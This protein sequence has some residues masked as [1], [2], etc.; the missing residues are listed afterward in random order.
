[1][2]F[3]TLDFEVLII[4]FCV[5]K[6]KCRLRNCNKNGKKLKKKRFFMSILHF[7][8]FGKPFRLTKARWNMLS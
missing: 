7:L 5:V 3:Y 2:L 8:K 6:C 1:M 4:A